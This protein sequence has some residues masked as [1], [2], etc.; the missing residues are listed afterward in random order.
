MSTKPKPRPNYR[1]KSVRQ[2]SFLRG[3]INFNSGRSTCDCLIRD[4][5]SN[6]ARLVFPS[7]VTT[8]DVFDLYISKKEQTLSARVTW[9]GDG[10]VGVTFAKPL[11]MEHLSE[12]DNLTQRVIQLEAKIA[13]LKRAFKKL[14]SKADLELDI[15]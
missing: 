8:P 13:S 14:K 5:S 12:V 9:R 7:T 15:A 2:R 4:I 3:L 11:S 10:E 6:G 1:R